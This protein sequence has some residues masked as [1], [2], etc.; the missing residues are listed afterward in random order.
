MTAISFASSRVATHGNEHAA[1]LL[2]ASDENPVTSVI[3]LEAR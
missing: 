2:H 1:D 3:N